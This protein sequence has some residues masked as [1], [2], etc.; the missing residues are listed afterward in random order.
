M[1]RASC[2]YFS[3]ILACFL[4]SPSFFYFLGFYVVPG[5]F[6]IVDVK[7]SIKLVN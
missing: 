5:T 6:E 7:F 1:C 2:S 4:F 3:Y